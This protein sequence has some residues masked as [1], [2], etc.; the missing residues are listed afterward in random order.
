MI[1]GTELIPW[2]LQKCVATYKSKEDY[3][4]FQNFP[5]PEKL[6]E[7]LAKAT[8]NW[9]LDISFCDD[10]AIFKTILHLR[11]SIWLLL[12]IF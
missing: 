1:F 12:N 8:C 3:I 2:I 10:I 4:L 9:A 11:A 5:I 7:L 6:C